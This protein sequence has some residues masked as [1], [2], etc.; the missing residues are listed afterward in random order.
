MSAVLCAFLQPPSSSAA[1][2]FEWYE[3]EHVPGRL[4][5]PGFVGAERYVS[6]DSGTSAL[7]VYRLRDLSVLTSPTYRALQSRTAA[8]TV[9]RMGSLDTFVRVTADVIQT[10]GDVDGAAP[11][12]LVLGFD[13][14]DEHRGVESWYQHHGGGIVS[15]AGV[16]G[17]RLVDVRDTN[18]PLTRLA[19][20]H[21]DRMPTSGSEGA[22]T[23]GVAPVDVSNETRVAMRQLYRHVASLASDGSASA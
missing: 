3:H 21:L 2:F 13:A 12:L 11:R 1:G 18:R 8:V 4:S 14:R 7:L 16:R 22:A 19:L 20:L 15:S 10:H 6:A 23:A 9:E 17:I 5:V